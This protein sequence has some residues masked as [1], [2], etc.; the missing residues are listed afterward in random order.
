MQPCLPAG[1]L[2]FLFLLFQD[3]ILKELIEYQF[4]EI[5]IMKKEKKMN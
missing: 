4:F 3:T 1:R 5:P 2:E